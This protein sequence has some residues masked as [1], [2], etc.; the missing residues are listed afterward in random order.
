MNPQETLV[1]VALGLDDPGA[2]SNE[3]VAHCVDA[4]GH[5]GPFGAHADPDLTAGLV[6]PATRHS[7]RLAWRAT[8]A[9]PNALSE[10]ATQKGAF[11]CRGHL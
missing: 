1:R 2:V 10:P 9:D 5:L 6:Q 7:R 11:S 4:S 3:R 8:S